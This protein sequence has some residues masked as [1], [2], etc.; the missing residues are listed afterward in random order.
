VRF[1]GISYDYESDAVTV[2]LLP[3][4]MPG[5]F[6]LN[7]AVDGSDFLAWQRQLGSSPVMAGAG[8]D[9]NGDGLVDGDD[10]AVWQQSFGFGATPPAA[11]VPEARAITLALMG[12]VSVGRFRAGRFARRRALR[13]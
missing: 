12:L 4:P 9:G 6:D 3:G 2:S 5:D 13:L 8:A 10:L 1:D 7:G 11:A